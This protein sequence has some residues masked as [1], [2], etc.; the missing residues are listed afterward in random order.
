[1]E[2]RDDHCVTPPDMALPTL[3]DELARAERRLF[4][5]RLTMTGGNRAEAARLLGHSPD[6]LV[7]ENA[8]ITALITK[9]NS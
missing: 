1:M 3:K 8:T 6:R 5:A 7:S 4:S 9:R 2:I